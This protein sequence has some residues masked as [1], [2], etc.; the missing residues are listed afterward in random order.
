M[1]AEETQ[2]IE[3]CVT[4]L[5]NGSELSW[6]WPHWHMLWTRKAGRLMWYPRFC[7]DD[8]WSD[9]GILECTVWAYFDQTKFTFENA[10]SSEGSCVCTPNLPITQFSLVSL[11]SPTEPRR[12]PSPWT[13][14]STAALVAVRICPHSAHPYIPND[15]CDPSSS[16]PLSR[17]H[18][19]SMPKHLL[20]VSEAST[21]LISL[22][23]SL[24]RKCSMYTVSLMHLSYSHSLW[25]ALL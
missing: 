18:L 25:R 13:L 14:R 3:S 1:A 4:Q 2:P 7:D 11:L 10:H 9:P 23:S 6:R 19:Q 22:N 5:S 24:N 16:P 20:Q 21:I 8:L 15:L 12:R 17:P